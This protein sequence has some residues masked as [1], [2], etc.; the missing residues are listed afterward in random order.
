[1]PAFKRGQLVEFT[2]EP[3]R[4]YTLGDTTLA[5][6]GV[7]LADTDGPTVQV[8]TPNSR[9]QS[10]GKTVTVPL[11]RIQASGWAGWMP[12]D[13]EAIHADING[14]ADDSGWEDE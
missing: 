14:I 5:R 7:V 4:D 1:M 6:Y 8:Q 10:H 13:L 2:D 3:Q 11:N 9:S 12:E